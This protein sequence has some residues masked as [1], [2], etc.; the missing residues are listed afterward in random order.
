MAFHMLR[1]ALEDHEFLAP[2][3]VAA[4]EELGIDAL[5]AARDDPE[6]DTA[7]VAANEA[8]EEAAEE[9]DYDE[10]PYELSSLAHAAV[11]E[12]T[13]NGELAGYV[14]DDFELIGRALAT[15]SSSEFLCSLWAAYAR[16]D[17]PR[18]PLRSLGVGGSLGALVREHLTGS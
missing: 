5:L 1:H 9:I 14:S 18:Q 12:V 13:G 17:L 10:N 6:F 2:G 8:V 15:G 16:G 7:W 11:F 4:I 3:L